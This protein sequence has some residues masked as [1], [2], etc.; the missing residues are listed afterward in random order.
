MNKCAFIRRVLTPISKWHKILYIYTRK[1]S[2]L[3][4]QP[5]FSHTLIL[6]ISCCDQHVDSASSVSL[7]GFAFNKVSIKSLNV[8]VEVIIYPSE[9]AYTAAAITPPQIILYKSGGAFSPSALISSSDCILVHPN[10]SNKENP[11]LSVDTRKDPDSPPGCN[12]ARL[13]G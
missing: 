1:G 7:S 5:R 4:F 11:A 10:R 12:K 3:L 9:S 13:I 2:R 6:Y 8:R